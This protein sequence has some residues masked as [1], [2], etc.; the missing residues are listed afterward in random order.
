VACRCRC[1]VLVDCCCLQS[2]RH[3]AQAIRAAAATVAQCSTLTSIFYVHPLRGLCCRLQ[4]TPHIA[5]AIRAA[6]LEGLSM[7]LLLPLL[8]PNAK[9]MCFLCAVSAAACSPHHTSRRPYVLQCWR[10]CLLERGV[11]CMRWRLRSAAGASGWMRFGCS[12]P[13]CGTACR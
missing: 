12:T 3:I 8:S 7:L 1:S 5:Q 4:S 13:S 11:W 6:V 10:A 9:P 2:T